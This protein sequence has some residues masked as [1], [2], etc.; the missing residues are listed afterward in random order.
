MVTSEAAKLLRQT[1]AGRLM[2]GAP[3]DLVVIPALAGEPG[4]ALLEATRRDVRLVVVDGR[5]LVG[6][7]D[8]AAVFKARKVVAR[9][10]RVDA[11]A[12]LGDSGLVRRIAGCPIDEPGVWVA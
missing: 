5:P 8:F 11:V 10:L 3:A 2:I 6:D 12:K 7:P 4:P 9:P 1:R